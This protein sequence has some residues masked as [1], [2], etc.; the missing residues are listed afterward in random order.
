VVSQD[1]DLRIFT[2]TQDDV[3]GF[4]RLHAWVHQSESE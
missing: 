4:D 3:F 1:G 2:S